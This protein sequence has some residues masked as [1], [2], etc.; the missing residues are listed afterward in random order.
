MDCVYRDVF[1]INSLPIHVCRCGCLEQQNHATYKILANKDLHPR[2]RNICSKSLTSPDFIKYSPHNVKASPSLLSN[3]LPVSSNLVTKLH[4]SIC[5]CRE[6]AQ[7]SSNSHVDPL[8]FT[9]NLY[10]PN[11]VSSSPVK[12][13]CG[14]L[15]VKYIDGKWCSLYGKKK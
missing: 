14:L 4:Q 8:V 7:F 10:C 1:Y 13:E 15:N 6:G 2:C 12:T 11:F 3:F 9:H 5:N